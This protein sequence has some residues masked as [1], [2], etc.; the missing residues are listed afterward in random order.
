MRRD[1]CRQLVIGEAGCIPFEAAVA[2]D[3]LGSKGPCRMWQCL[4]AGDEDD[5]A[6]WPTGVRLVVVGKRPCSTGSRPA[7]TVLPHSAVAVTAA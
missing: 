1:R 2:T 5:R 3:Q 4:S 6:S 7:S